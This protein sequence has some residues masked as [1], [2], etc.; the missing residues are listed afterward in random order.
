M[1][2]QL[3]L[4][5]ND[6]DKFIDHCK[7]CPGTFAIK[8]FIDGKIKKYKNDNDDIITCIME[9]IE[10]HYPEIDYDLD[11]DTPFYTLEILNFNSDYE[12]EKDPAVRY[13]YSYLCFL[14]ESPKE[15]NKIMGIEE[16][17][18]PVFPDKSFNTGLDKDRLSDLFRHLYD[19]GFVE[20]IE[21]EKF[22]KIFSNEPLENIDAIRWLGKTKG[23]ADMQTLFEMI[24]H[25]CRWEYINAEKQF[26]FFSK[27]NS[28]FIRPDGKELLIDNI[29]TRYS[30]WKREDITSKVLRNFNPQNNQH[31]LIKY[32]SDFSLQ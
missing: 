14:S 4:Y 30:L 3:D 11:D 25:L 13:L 7:E 20:K 23:G 8:V 15:V 6:Y 27:V 29:E 16:N 19:Y 26:I 18:L 21:K 12:G 31:R 1:A 24:K 2:N 22:L 10:R 17:G 5:Y 28:C 32:L 9:R